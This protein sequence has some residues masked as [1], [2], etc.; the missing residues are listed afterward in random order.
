VAI[1]IPVK[2][3]KFLILKRADWTR[4]GGFWN[5]PG[6]SVDEGETPYEAG[7]REL[8][9]EAD[10]Y[11][12][13]EQL[14]YFGKMSMENKLLHFYGTKT[15]DGEVTINK[16]SSDFVWITIPELKN[17]KFLPLEEW[18]EKALEEYIGA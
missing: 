5:F 13:E 12:D 4:K 1:L 6:G 18:L 16:E 11:A 15:F 8:E 7:V 2:N 3:G 9:E 17:Y 10:L 14:K